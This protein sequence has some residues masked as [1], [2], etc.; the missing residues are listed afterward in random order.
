MFAH[1]YSYAITNML[2]WIDAY[3]LLNSCFEIAAETGWWWR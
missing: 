2:Q 3:A 1:S